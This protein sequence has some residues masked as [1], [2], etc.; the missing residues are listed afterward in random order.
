[1]SYIVHSVWLLRIDI[2]V[3]C[4]CLTFACGFIYLFVF[5]FLAIIGCELMI[6]M[7][8]LDG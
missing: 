5:S 2:V 1:M 4:G 3:S 6:P 8:E 7:W